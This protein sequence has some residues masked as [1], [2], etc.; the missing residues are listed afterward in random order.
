MVAGPGVVSGVS[1]ALAS[2]IDLAATFLDFAGLPVPGSMDSLSLRK[3]LSGTTET[4]RRIVRSGLGEWRMA[5]DGRF[6]SIANFET[7]EGK[8]GRAAPGV[9]PLLFDLMDDPGE[10]RNVAIRHPEVVNRLQSYLPVG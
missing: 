9:N 2:H 3:V 6:K 8:V 1:G 4:H 5:W 10:T 7:R